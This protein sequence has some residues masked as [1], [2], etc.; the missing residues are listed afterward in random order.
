[1]G[2]VS[3]RK[4]LE[5]IKAKAMPGRAV[6]FD[7]P[8]RVLIDNKASATNTVIEIN[9]RDRPGFLRDVTQ[10][11]TQLGLQISSAHVTTYGERAVDVFYVRDVFGLKIE[12]DSKKKMIETRLMAAIK[13]EVPPK[14]APPPAPVRAPAA[15]AAKKPK[16]ARKSKK[17]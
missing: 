16:K 5:V 14:A 3:A 11:L 7:V 12:Q 10:A 8:P 6:A 1:S 9:G 13:G 4:E 17:S 2:K 15:P